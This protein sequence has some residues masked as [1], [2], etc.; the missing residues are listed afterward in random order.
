MYRRSWHWAWKSSSDTLLP[1][2]CWTLTLACCQSGEE[3]ASEVATEGKSQKQAM[4]EEFKEAKRQICSLLGLPVR[5]F[6]QLTHD[7]ALQKVTAP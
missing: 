1:L 4:R 6:T 5:L 3:N 2:Y 7:N